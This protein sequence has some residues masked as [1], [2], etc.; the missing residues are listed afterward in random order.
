MMEGNI[1]LHDR[2]QYRISSTGYLLAATSSRH[3]YSVEGFS[4]QR[5]R[6]RAEPPSLPWNEPVSSGRIAFQLHISLPT[7]QPLRPG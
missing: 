3:L 7:Y 5:P 4:Q 1:P 6:R 2:R